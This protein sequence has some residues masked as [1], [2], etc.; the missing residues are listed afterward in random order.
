MT[1]REAKLLAAQLAQLLELLQHNSNKDARNFHLS[2]QANFFSRHRR[3]L[4]NL[5]Y[6]ANSCISHIQ[7]E[8]RI[9]RIIGYTAKF[10]NQPGIV[11]QALR[12]SGELIGT[13]YQKGSESISSLTHASTGSTT[14]II[15]QIVLELM[16]REVY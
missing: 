12:G 2:N 14:D 13:L 3:N 9:D 8:L 7:A 16:E 4:L 6:S 5:S 1:E 15:D 11:E 10:S